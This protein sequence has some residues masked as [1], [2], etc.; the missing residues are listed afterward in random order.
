MQPTPQATRNGKPV[1]LVPPRMRV[2]IGVCGEANYI[3]ACAY[4]PFLFFLHT[5]CVHIK[6]STRECSRLAKK[7][8]AVGPLAWRRL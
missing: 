8:V 1:T 5:I 2:C 3:C 6:L 4:V 7:I